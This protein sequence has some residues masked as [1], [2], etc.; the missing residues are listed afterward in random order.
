MQI[1]DCRMR[2]PRLMNKDQ[3]QIADCRIQNE[4]DCRMHKVE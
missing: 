3:L 4:T 1:A 2:N